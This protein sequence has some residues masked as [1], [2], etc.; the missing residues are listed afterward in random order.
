M[1]EQFCPSEETWNHKLEKDQAI[2]T[3]PPPPPPT[4]PGTNNK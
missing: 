1:D 4:H 2:D 3:D